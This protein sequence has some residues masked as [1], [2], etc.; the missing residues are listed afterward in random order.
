M[1]SRLH[2]DHFVGRTV[3]G[4]CLPITVE[5]KTLQPP[6]MRRENGDVI[7]RI[8]LD[9]FLRHQAI[10]GVIAVD[11]CP[12]RRGAGSSRSHRGRSDC[13]AGWSRLPQCGRLPAAQRLPLRRFLRLLGSLLLLLGRRRK[14]SLQHQFL[15][16]NHQ[17]DGNNDRDQNST[18]IQNSVPL[19]LPLPV[20]RR[21]CQDRA[22]HVVALPV[23]ERMKVRVSQYSALRDS[24][25]RLSTPAHW[26]F[27]FAALLCD[28]PD[29][30]HAHPS[31]CIA[32]FATR[33]HAAANDAVF[34]DRVTCIHRAA[35]LEPASRPVHRMNQWRDR[36]PINRYCADAIARKIAR[37]SFQSICCIRNHHQ[38]C[39]AIR[40]AQD[41]GPPS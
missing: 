21:S 10:D 24:G 18:R 29:R 15:V 33:H 25:F 32:R 7:I 35:R 28:S 2:C 30:T 5:H 13:T 19:L 20:E 38:P 37:R 16:R 8:H 17:D 12:R 40:P 23:W 27:T 9:R 26:T 31:G 11:C 39:P 36:R 3:L 41:C 14:K 22:G 6:A 4:R 1:P 34:R